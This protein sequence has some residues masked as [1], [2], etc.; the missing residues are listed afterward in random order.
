M[1]QISCERSIDLHAN[2]GGYWRMHI[3]YSQYTLLY[4]HAS[5]Q[6]GKTEPVP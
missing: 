1:L 2:T 5:G 3:R 6:S 4:L